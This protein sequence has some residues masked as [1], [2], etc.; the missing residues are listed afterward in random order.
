MALLAGAA[1]AGALSTPAAVSVTV[2]PGH[3]LEPGT[4][5][6]TVRS[7]GKRVE[8]TIVAP[9]PAS[10][11]SDGPAAPAATPSA[12]ASSVPGSAQDS[13]AA[14][15]ARRADGSGVG[16]G[17]LLLVLL[18]VLVL[19]GGGAMTYVRVVA[20]RRY[21][22]PYRRALDEMS[23]QRYDRAL[24]TLT[25]LEA[26]LPPRVRR[27]A[28]FFIA[29]AQYRLGSREAAEYRLT[30]L[31]RE[32]A[33]NADVA[34]LLAYLRAERGDFDGAEAVLGGLDPERLTANDEQ[35]RLLGMVQVNRAFAAFR[36]GRIDAAAE[37]FEQVE[38][39]GD[40]AEHVPI[41]LRNR[42]ILVGTRALFD[43]DV[44]AAREQF[45]A[46]YRAA[47]RGEEPERSTMLAS[48]QLG[49]A[50]SAW[51]TKDKDA[52]VQTEK[53]LVEVLRSLDPE[54]ALAA[55]WP[56][57]PDP[58]LPSRIEDMMLR[59]NRPPAEIDR[60]RTL[61]DIHFLCGMAEL[62]GW[63]E[64][65]RR[66]AQKGDARSFEAASRCFARCRELDPEF[67][68]VYVVVGLLRFYLANDKAERQAGLVVLRE[69]RKLGTRDPEILRILNRDDRIRRANRDASE[70]FLQ[71][72][73]RYVRDPTVRAEVRE[74]L[75]ARM[76][77]HGKVRD[78]DAR[79][80]LVHARSVAPTVSEVQARSELLRARVADLLAD[81]AGSA[82]LSEARTLTDDLEQRSR[83]MAQYARAVEEQEARLLELLGD[84]LLR[85]VEG[86]TP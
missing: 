49:L 66:S 86:W 14:A 38:R 35:R 27:E 71:V 1:P 19:F 17:T 81:H 41:D 70:V 83:A 4:Y 44:P 21:V 8:L 26:T 69:A 18:A 48:A 68:D 53:L 36:K 73:D 67:S 29:F 2:E 46:L 3:T 22:R 50:L 56:D 32:D 24:P 39:L 20:P 61:R 60:V 30:E 85:E 13:P 76:S 58:G 59:A 37:L 79:P 34:Y 51:Q 77:R 84:T 74:A 33:D 9:E 16:V 11:A 28:R 54:G 40:F 42:N 75:L 78:W 10:R 52:A 63:A 62:R 6:V 12:S 23:V 55:R 47:R 15:S 65:D 43:R 80:D 25:R 7:D 5:H 31:N 64:R 82:D 45:D 72:L 57:G